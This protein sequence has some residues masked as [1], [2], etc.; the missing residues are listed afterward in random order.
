MVAQGG[1]I[2]PIPGT[3][4]I[5]YLEENAGAVHVQFPKEELSTI[6]SI[7]PKD[8]AAGLRYPEQAMK[9]VNK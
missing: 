7:A 5:K 3:K 1:Y 9:T 8:V 6:N 2:F 4:G